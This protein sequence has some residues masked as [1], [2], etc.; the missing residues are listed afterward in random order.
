MCRRAS[1]Q[2]ESKQ[3]HEISHPD[4]MQGLRLFSW[5]S[6]TVASL[7]IVAICMYFLLSEMYKLFPG[8]GTVAHAHAW[9][10]S[11]IGLA[12]GASHD[13]GG[14]PFVD[15][16]LLLLKRRIVNNETAFGRM[17]TIGT[18]KMIK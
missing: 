9:Y 4:A 11:S 6:F 10:V 17:L 3:R 14:Q 15:A 8:T 1:C 16:Q 12:A 5:S 7:P 2:S 13:A 18:W